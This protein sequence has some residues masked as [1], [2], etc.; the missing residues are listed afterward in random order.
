MYYKTK[1]QVHTLTF[2][3]LNTHDG[4]RYVHVWDEMN[5][6]LTSD[7][8]AW[9]YFTHVKE[10]LQE[11]PT[12]ET[13]IVWSDGCEYQ[14]RNARLSN[15]LLELAQLTNVTIIQKYLISGHT[16]MECDSMHSCIERYIKGPIYCLRN[17]VLS[18]QSERL[19]PRP[20]KVS[21]IQ[22]SD[23]QTGFENTRLTSIRPGKKTGG[24]VVTGN[25]ELMYN[26]TSNLS[27]KYKMNFD[28]E[29]RVLLQRMKECEEV[30][31][32]PLY[33]GVIP[34]KARKYND[35]QS[36]MDVISKHLH[37]Y[38]YQDIIHP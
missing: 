26:G 15:A 22:F 32:T 17:Y 20:Y 4:S 28:D 29:W 19:N 36:L 24:H 9:F 14:N 16:Q 7:V 10:Y 1:L 11:N 30:M 37:K 6:G 35:L 25:R 21:E 38:L 33:A 27:I 12:V 3:E 13:L 5:G 8:F 2:Y 18:M 31:L 34:I 23:F